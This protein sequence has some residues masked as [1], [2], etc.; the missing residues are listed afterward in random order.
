MTDKL[1]ITSTFTKE[2]L[3]CVICYV[4]IYPPL[5][6]CSQCYYT[7]MCKKC[8]SKAGPNCPTCRTSPM[9]FNKQLENQLEF[10]NCEYSSCPIKMLE[11]DIN[12]H[13]KECEYSPQ[14]CFFCSTMITSET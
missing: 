7:F 1:T 14:K 3:Q 10:K 6:Q 11:W 8:A 12:S 2:D 5:I 13:S 4:G 9:F